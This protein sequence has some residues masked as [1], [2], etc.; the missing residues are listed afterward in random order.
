[1]P[2]LL[3]WFRKPRAEA[4]TYSLCSL[5][6]PEVT[7]LILAQVHALNRWQAGDH[8]LSK[9]GGSP[10]A[11]T[12]A[13]NQAELLSLLRVCK[14]WYLAGIA[15][16]YS[17]PFLASPHAVKLFTRT[18]TSRQDLARLLVL[19][20]ESDAGSVATAKLQ[21]LEELALAD[22][23]GLDHVQLPAM[24]ALR[25]L[26]IWRAI[27][28]VFFEH[29]VPPSKALPMLEKIELVGSRCY[30][31]AL[32]QSIQ[33]YS[34]TLKELT[35]IGLDELCVARELDLA[36]FTVLRRLVLGPIHFSEPPFGVVSMPASLEVFIALRADATS[37]NLECFFRSAE[38]MGR[39][40]EARLDLVASR[41]EGAQLLAKVVGQAPLKLVC[42]CREWNITLEQVNPDEP[43]LFGEERHPTSS[44]TLPFVSSTLE[45]YYNI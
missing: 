31:G 22:F 1:M 12:A 9:S 27:S 26:R 6:P 37:S 20:V 5:L 2:S 13:L 18:V 16:L 28:D 34:R 15:T 30:V 44:F 23:C 32:I 17:E 24:P 14:G 7:L 42:L 19:T 41:R 11:C 29:A 21:H 33:S 40:L 45:D 35:L 8:W 25:T 4:P 38:E 3:L 39:C 36:A 43:G 10:D